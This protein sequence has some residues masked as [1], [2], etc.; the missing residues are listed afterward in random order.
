MIIE[1][2]EDQI[3]SAGPLF[4]TLIMIATLTLLICSFGA[5]AKKEV[6][7]INSMNMNLVYDQEHLNKLHTKF[8]CC[9]HSSGP[10][11]Y[12]SEMN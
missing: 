2:F 10:F 7:I 6:I 8:I 4:I 9:S 12:G 11:W 1:S 5:G 3:Y